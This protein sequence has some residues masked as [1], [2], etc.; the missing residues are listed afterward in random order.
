MTRTLAGTMG[1]VAV[2]ALFG[3]TVLARDYYVAP[4]GG[5]SNPGTLEKPFKDAVKT[6]RKLMP[7]ENE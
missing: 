4:D 6:I 7:G 3:S 1:S 5:D 2:G